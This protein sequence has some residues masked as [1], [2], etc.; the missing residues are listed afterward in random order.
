[1]D[2]IVVLLFYVLYFGVAYLLFLL[3]AM[4]VMLIGQRMLN[5]PDVP[6]AG[7]KQTFDAATSLFVTLIWV[8]FLIGLVLRLSKVDPA[9]VTVLACMALLA[10]ATWFGAKSTVESLSVTRGVA[11]G[12]NAGSLLAGGATVV[13]IALG[14]QA[15]AT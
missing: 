3:P 1:M 2:F 14:I 15:I 9:K 5:K 11:L 6:T 13:S 12:L 7:W 8:G 4:A 10:A